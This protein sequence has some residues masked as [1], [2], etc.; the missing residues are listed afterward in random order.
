[1]GVDFLHNGQLK[2]VST[3]LQTELV[4]RRYTL[5]KG[6]TL[7]I[8]VEPKKDMK[9]RTGKSPDI[10][11]AAMLMIDLARQRFAFGGIPTKGT[12]SVTSWTN[13]ARKSDVASFGNRNRLTRD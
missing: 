13:M 4:A 12:K 3:A 7:R 8:C 11:D 6:N 9:V 10:A 5:V 2:G 1:V